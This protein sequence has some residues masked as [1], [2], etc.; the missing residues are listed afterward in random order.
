ML[1]YTWA[2][3]SWFQTKYLHHLDAYAISQGAVQARRGGKLTLFP[4]LAPS[5]TS[6]KLH[7]PSKLPPVYL[8]NGANQRTSIRRLSGLFE[9]MCMTCLAFSQCFM[10]VS[11]LGCLSSHSPPLPG[12]E[13]IPSPCWALAYSRLVQQEPWPEAEKRDRH[14]LPW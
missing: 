7:G 4:I 14:F 3:V 5:R 1:S 2:Q 10:Q 12:L 6:S 11:V 9:I 13:P 8:Q